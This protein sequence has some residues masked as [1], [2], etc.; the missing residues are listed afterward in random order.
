MTTALSH[1]QKLADSYPN[2]SGITIVTHS[3][4]FHTDEV[5]AA[6]IL[7]YIFGC[8]DI[9][10]TRDQE[11][12][13]SHISNPKSFIIDVG[14]VYNPENNQFD[15]HQ[16]T[17]N[18]T[19]SENHKIPLSSCGLIYKHFGK[20]LWIKYSK[21]SEVDQELIDSF[22][23]NFVLP[24]DANDNGVKQFDDERDA[25]YYNNLTLVDFISRLN[26]ND[27][28]NHDIQLEKFK[29]GMD[30]CFRFLH[31][32]MSSHLKYYTNYKE[33]L[34]YFQDIYNYSKGSEILISKKDM[35]FNRYLKQL[36]NQGRVKFIVLPRGNN[37]QIYTVSKSRF[38]NMV[39]ILGES[40]AKK[41]IGENLIFVH[42]A[43]FIAS[44]RTK[45]SAIKLA[46]ASLKLYNSKRERVKR[47]FKKINIPRNALVFTG[48]VVLGMGIIGMFINK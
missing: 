48:G 17:F 40:E 27:K 41:E 28:Y 23:N 16:K 26:G 8:D 4:K 36:D 10:R 43:K 2:R 3:E 11:I 32:F 29:E 44:T 22:Y 18:L 24:I 37:W 46:E 33:D 6:T 12:I 34:T 9:I 45:D 13:N 5:M 30:N 7:D 20:D 35:S 39:D 19:Y 25:K 14:G 1:Y 38:E 31:L 15:H 42:R 21:S 47:L